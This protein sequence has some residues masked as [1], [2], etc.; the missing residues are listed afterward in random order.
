METPE[1]PLIFLCYAQIVDIYDESST[2]GRHESMR[3]T[4]VASR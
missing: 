3:P 4:E 1:T 2:W